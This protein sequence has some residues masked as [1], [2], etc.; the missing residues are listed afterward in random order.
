LSAFILGIIFWSWKTDLDQAQD[1]LATQQMSYLT[2]QIQYAMEV[3][4]DQLDQWPKL[5][6]GPGAQPDQLQRL[7][8]EPLSKVLPDYVYLPM[9]PWQ[10]AFALQLR[11]DGAWLLIGLGKDGSWSDQQDELAFSYPIFPPQ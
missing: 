11:E 10:G 4:E 2:G 6:V 1:R 7:N 5:L 8:P 3:Q 9:D